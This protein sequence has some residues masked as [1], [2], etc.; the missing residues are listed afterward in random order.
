MINKIIERGIKKSEVILKELTGIDIKM[1]PNNSKEIK[2]NEIINK[3]Y[4]IM[5]Q[6]AKSENKIWNF[7]FTLL[8]SDFLKFLGLVENFNNIENIQPEDVLDSFLEIGNIICGNVISIIAENEKDLSFTPPILHK[9]SEIKN[10]IINGITIK[11]EIK[12]ENISGYLL[13]AFKE[14][15]KNED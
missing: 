13:F 2:L 9:F 7:Y 8:S 1:Y 12:S 5:T 3:N 4:Y 14:G 11:F 10:D 15:V 6:S